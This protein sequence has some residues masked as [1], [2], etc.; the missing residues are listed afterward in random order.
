[1]QEDEA[2]QEEV[3]EEEEVGVQ[4]VG[5]Q[6]A[7]VEWMNSWKLGSHKLARLSH[8]SY[9]KVD[10]MGREAVE[11]HGAGNSSSPMSS[12]VGLEKSIHPL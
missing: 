5:A 2:A 8:Q 4:V 11:D 3:E 9:W 10:L 6:E 1:M 12:V 7:V